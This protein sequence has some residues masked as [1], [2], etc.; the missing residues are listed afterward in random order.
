MVLGL[1][2]KLKKNGWWIED[3]VE[4]VSPIWA[5]CDVIVAMLEFLH[6]WK[7]FGLWSIQ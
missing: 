1:L 5:L 4:W 2:W 3:F 6:F 7:G